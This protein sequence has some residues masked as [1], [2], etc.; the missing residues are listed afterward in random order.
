MLD[1]WSSPGGEGQVEAT[2]TASPRPAMQ[3][4]TVS[5]STTLPPHAIWFD[6][7]SLW[8]RAMLEVSPWSDS[9]WEQTETCVDL[10]RFTWVLL[11]P[12]YPFV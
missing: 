11:G 4:E 9:Q 8:G 3:M 7:V 12:L 2:A 1:L 5:L 6:L 10:R